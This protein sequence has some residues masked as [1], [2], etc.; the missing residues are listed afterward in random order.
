MRKHLIVRLEEL[1]NWTPVVVVATSAEEALMM[2][3]RQVYAKSKDFRD[4]V[5]TFFYERFCRADIN[6]EN[7][8]IK[9]LQQI[10]EKVMVYFVDRPDLG[11][12]Y[13][14]YFMNGDESEFDD[15][16]YEY[17]AIREDEGEHGLRAIDI[18]A[19]AVL[20]LEQS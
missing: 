15:D 3:L 16:M 2:Y 10:Q 8:D 7:I 19:C 18:D 17:I 1:A 5:E 20:T 6:L 12:R 11:R 9:E 4:E 13:C 14:Y